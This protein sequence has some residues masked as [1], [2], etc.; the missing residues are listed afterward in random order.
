MGTP[1]DKP[2]FGCHLSSARGFAAM[3]RTAKAIDATTFQFFTRNPRGTAAKPL[4]VADITALAAMV[5]ETGCGPLVAH[6]PY[7]VNPCSL[8]PELR[9]LAVTVMTDDLTRLEYLPKSLYVIHPG[10]HCGQGRD[11]GVSLIA[12]ALTSVLQRPWQTTILLETMSGKG[13]EVG[14]SFDELAMILDAVANSRQVGVCL[15]TCHVWDAGY[16][17]AGDLDGVLAAFDRIIGLKRLK[18]VHCNDNMNPRGSR[19]DRH[20][21]IGKGTIGLEAF[22]RIVNHPAL[23]HLPFCLETPNDLAGY[24]AEIALLRNMREE[25]PPRAKVSC[26]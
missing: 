19:K 18:V 12:E 21:Q 23:R 14:G 13:S 2:A 24:A 26:A 1:I 16:D 20:A 10:N 5:R 9:D 25:A 22:G 11:K 4:D 8:K 3:G 15:D 17:L 6:A 7:I